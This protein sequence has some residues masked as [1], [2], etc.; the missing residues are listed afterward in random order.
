MFPI[1]TRLAVQFRKGRHGSAQ[2][3]EFDT[4]T[5]SHGTGSVS[6]CANLPSLQLSTVEVLSPKFIKNSKSVSALVF[7]NT[8]YQPASFPSMSTKMVALKK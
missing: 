6:I 5:G 8:I 3:F 7:V 2:V 1:A 4:G